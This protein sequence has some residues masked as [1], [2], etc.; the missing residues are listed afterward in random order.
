M[1]LRALALILLQTVT[2]ASE[3]SVLDATPHVWVYP[4]R[5]ELETPGGPLPFILEVAHAVHHEP[6]DQ[7]FDFL[8]AMPIRIVNGEEY[9]VQVNTVSSSGGGY[10]GEVR[11]GTIDFNHYD[12]KLSGTGYAGCVIFGNFIERMYRGEW[13]KKRGGE[14]ATVPYRMIEAS[15][16]NDR[17]DPVTG[18]GEPAVFNGRWSVD[19]SSSDDLAIGVFEVDGNQN[20]QG[21]FMTTTGDYRYLAGRVDGNLMRLSTFDG[22]HA[23]LFHARM[24]DDGTIEGDFWSGNW[25]HETWTATRDDDATLP[26]AFEQ[27]VIADEDALDEMVFKNLEG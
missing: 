4:T 2:Y 15:S 23:F 20:A 6:Y 18:S 13:S 10:G 11:R 21:T 27:T 22:A 25:W 12:S 9:L 16:T 7:Y 26:D 19:F 5:V 24:Q 3:P 14:Y 8:R 17:F 1:I